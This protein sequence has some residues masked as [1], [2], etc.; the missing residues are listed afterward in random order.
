[1]TVFKG[2]LIITKRNLLMVFMYLA[3]FLTIGILQRVPCPSTHGRCGR[4]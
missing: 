3:I 1:M 4:S 2:F